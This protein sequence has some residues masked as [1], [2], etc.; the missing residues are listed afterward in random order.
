MGKKGLLFILCFGLF[1]C[2]SAEE[3][4]AANYRYEEALH[5]QCVYNLNFMPG[6][7]NYMD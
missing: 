3:R 4:R 2:V 6:T 1:A 5:N 7:Q